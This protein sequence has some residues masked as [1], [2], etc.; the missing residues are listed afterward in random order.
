MIRIVHYVTRKGRDYFDEW[1]RNQTSQVR[2]RVQARIDRVGLGNFGDSKGLG[3]G[4][5]ELRIDFG[6]GYRV[7]Y[8]RDGDALVILLGG[9]TKQ[10]QGRDI[11]RA[12]A[13]WEEY[14]QEKR[15]ALERT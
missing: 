4:V 10:R 9:G 6:A 15:D 2:A 1:L 12:H 5:S 8:E 3:K 14:N 13:L 11:E 7:Y